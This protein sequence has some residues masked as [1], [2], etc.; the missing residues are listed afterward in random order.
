MYDTTYE[1]G[2][3]EAAGRQV[4]AVEGCEKKEVEKEKKEK[5]DEPTQ[6]KDIIS[7]LDPVEGYN[8]HHILRVHKR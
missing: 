4:H 2:W 5:I 8:K 1:Y 3:A 6:H 7:M